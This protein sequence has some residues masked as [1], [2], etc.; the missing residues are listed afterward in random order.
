MLAGHSHQNEAKL[1]LH[2]Y[3]SRC[4]MDAEL[5]ASLSGAIIGMKPSSQTTDK[6]EYFMFRIITCPQ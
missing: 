2:K 5:A 6:D 3:M 4:Y 1:V